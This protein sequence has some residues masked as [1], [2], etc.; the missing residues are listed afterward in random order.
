MKITRE[1]DYA[2]R[3]MI[4]LAMAKGRLGASEIA[5]DTAISQRFA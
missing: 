4:R 2:I 5:E 3:I 1:A